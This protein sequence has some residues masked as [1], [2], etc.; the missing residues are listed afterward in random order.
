MVDVL[1]T[2]S[3]FLRFDPKEYEAMMPYPPLGTLYAAAWIRAHGYTVALFDSMLAESEQELEAAIRTHRPRVVAIYDDDFNYLT[4]MCLTRMREAA[5]R[6]SAIAREAGC[7]V[8]VHGSDA[9]DHLDSYFTHDADFVLC[10]EGEHTLLEILDVLL[11][12]KGTADRVQGLAYVESGNVR[13]TAERPV[14]KDLDI[15]PFPARDLVDNSEYRRRW[16]NHHG[17]FSTNIV[18]TRGCP[19]HC[20]WCAKPLYGQVYNSRSPRSVAEE[21]KFLKETVAPDHL[22]FCDDIFGLK[23]G[24]VSAF[25]EEVTALD[26]SIPFKCL[27][28]VDL[29]LRENAVANLARSG[30][31]TVWVGAESGSQKIL[32]AMEKGTTVDQIEEA[33]RRLKAS[34]IRVGFFLQYGYPGETREDINMT[35]AMVQRCL[36]DEIGISVSYPLPGTPFYESVRSQLGEKQNWSDSRDLAMMFAGSFHPDFYRTLHRVTHKRFRIWHGSEAVRRSLRNP[37]TLNATTLRAIAAGAYHSLTLPGEQ[38]KLQG[39]ET[40]DPRAR[41]SSPPSQ[42]EAIP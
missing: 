6:M 8:V 2:H 3:Y 37:L 29:L 34:G 11:R 17:Y 16:T 42:A 35:L 4:K 40:L 30:C 23:P 12:G 27:A 18:T 33:T 14:V 15:F 13:R 5:F 24:W 41:F 25:A 21:M 10:G 19:F 26:A 39:L 28:R 32:D 7:T 38:R 9:V 31:T 1:F 22:W 36:P 20:N